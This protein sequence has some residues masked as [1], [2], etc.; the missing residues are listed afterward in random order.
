MIGTVA[1]LYLRMSGGWIPGGMFFSDCCPN[2]VTC[3]IARLMSTPG[4]KNSLMTDTPGY[5]VDSTCSMS[6]MIVV[7]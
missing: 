1:A 2:A 3:A 6:L 4:W 5:V 7:A